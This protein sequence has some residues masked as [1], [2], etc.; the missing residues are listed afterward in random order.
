MK[1]SARG[2]EQS[3]KEGVRGWFCRERARL[4]PDSLADGKHLLRVGDET[5]PD[6]AQRRERREAPPE[7]DEHA[8]GRRVRDEARDEGTLL[9]VSESLGEGPRGGGGEERRL[10]GGAPGLALAQVLQEQQ[11]AELSPL[12]HH[13]CWKQRVPFRKEETEPPSAGR[14]NGRAGGAAY[15]ARRSRRAGTKENKGRIRASMSC[16]A[17]SAESERCAA[18]STAASPPG[19]AT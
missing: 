2:V 12:V 9:Q 13:L 4:S 14:H 17:T 7:P 8:R 6:L 10:A 19:S 3:E 1:L 16:L 18:S 11:R 5:L 15:L